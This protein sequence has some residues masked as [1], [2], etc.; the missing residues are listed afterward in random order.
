M[1]GECVSSIGEYAFYDCSGIS[2]ITIPS[3]VTSIGDNAFSCSSIDTV[4]I[5]SNA[6]LS[7]SYTSS[8]N[9]GSSFG[10]QVKA[11]VFGECVSSIGEYA[12]YDCSGITSITI[13]SS[14]T[15]IV[16]NAFYGCIGLTSIKVEPG[17]TKYDS[18]NG[19]NAIIETATNTLVFGC[20]NTVIPYGVTGIGDSAFN[21]CSGLTSMSIPNSV[22]SI[23]DGAFSDCSGLT[24]IT[25]PNSVTSIG[26]YAFSGCSGFHS[27]SI[28]NSVTSIGDGVFSDCGGLIWLTI[29][30]SITSIGDYSFQN[31][32]NLTLITIPDGVTSI[33]NYAFKNCKSLVSITIPNSV[34]S[35]G[36]YS[37][38]DC[39]GL[40]TISLGAELS[41]IGTKA[42]LG[43]TSLT[44]IKSFAII[45]PLCGIQALYDIN[46]LK[47]VLIVPES[48]IDNYRAADQWRDFYN[49]I[50]NAVFQVSELVVDVKM[51]NGTISVS[52]MRDGD[53]VLV[54]DM[55]GKIISSKTAINGS[56]ELSITHIE[57]G[58]QLIIK[59]GNYNRKIMV[60]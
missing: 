3:S 29:P 24:S 9:L 4:T 27:I 51:E 13:P 33:G 21:N 7:H 48:S 8:H 15:S 36:D 23:G 39:S 12:F 55:N 2:S 11:Y 17:N 1:F 22:T 40:E 25:I 42:F 19:C 20:K 50:V 44:E 52:G 49:I 30:N 18:R 46:V 28:P 45:P 59:I 16:F 32:T 54:Y 38:S 10:N 14:V 41:V 6:L 56:A 35:I 26:N 5:N 31:C 58:T 47:C 60:L 37:F 53:L 43:C 57:K 34:R